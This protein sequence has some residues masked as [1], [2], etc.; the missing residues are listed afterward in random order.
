MGMLGSSYGNL[1]GMD[2]AYTTYESAFSWGGPH[3]GLILGLPIDANTVD[4]SASPNYRLRP[5]LLL[6]KVT[7]TGKLM[8]YDATATNGTQVAF[9]V[10]MQGLRM[11]DVFSGSAVDKW[12]GVLVAGPIQAAKVNGL[13]DQ[14]RQQM[15]G[16]FTFDD[17]PVGLQREVTIRE[18]A[19][20]ANYTV[21][22]T[23]KLNLFTNEGATAAVVFTLPTIAAGMRFQFLA[24][25][26]Y[27]MKVTKAG[28]A[29]MF[30]FNNANCTSV[31]F[32]TA[33]AIVGGC[34][35]VVASQD[36]GAWYVFNRSA[37]ANTITVA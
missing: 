37:G 35:E 13:D 25:A 21:L 16:R 20:T 27:N 19:K 5:G 22:T 33:N 18:V 14:A 32:E 36:G 2:S 9:G 6:G 8:Q 28:S 34:V 24:L 23:D 30:A 7:T 15:F 26:N 11:E 29:V 10:L 31:S 12:L 1:P 4:S 3:R 17:D